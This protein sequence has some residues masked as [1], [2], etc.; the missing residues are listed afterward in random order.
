MKPLL[1]LFVVLAALAAAGCSRGGGEPDPVVT[2]TPLARLRYRDPRPGMW[3]LYRPAG[4]NGWERFGEP[5]VDPFT[6]LDDVAR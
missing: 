6:L 3:S 4:E 1:A 2:T 5:A